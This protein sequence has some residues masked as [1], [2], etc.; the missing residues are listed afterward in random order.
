MNHSTCCPWLGIYFSTWFAAWYA[1]SDTEVPKML[2]SMLRYPCPYC[3][4]CWSV[5]TFQ[6][7]P[8]H[9]DRHFKIED[10]TGCTYF[11]NFEWGNLNVQVSTPGLAS[12]YKL[13]QT[14]GLTPAA[15]QSWFYSPPLTRTAVNIQ[16]RVIFT[17][18]IAS[19]VLSN[20]SCNPQAIKFPRGY[21]PSQRSHGN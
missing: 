11:L 2:V 1:H 15:P 3:Q 13:C 16:G 12:A 5:I 18:K 7:F 10:S 19:F 20:R 14:L 21:G 6:T 4:G 9:V 17:K 8:S